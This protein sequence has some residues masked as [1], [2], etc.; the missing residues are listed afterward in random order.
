MDNRIDRFL[1]LSTDKKISSDGIYYKFSNKEIEFLPENSEVIFLSYYDGSLFVTYYHNED[2]IFN[3]KTHHVDY[4]GDEVT[5]S[6]IVNWIKEKIKLS[7]GKN[8]G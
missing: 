4:D 3:R 8:N 6:E 2:N 1:S 5:M 7:T